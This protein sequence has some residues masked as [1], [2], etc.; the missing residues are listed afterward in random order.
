MRHKCPWLR[1]Q[2][3]ISGE[4]VLNFYF[5]FFFG[6]ITKTTVFVL[7]RWMFGCKTWNCLRGLVSVKPYSNVS[8]NLQQQAKI[9]I[10]S[11]YRFSPVRLNA[12]LDPSFSRFATKYPTA[13]IPAFY[14]RCS[15]LKL[16]LI[17]LDFFDI[18]ASREFFPNEVRSPE[19][20]ETSPMSPFKKI[21]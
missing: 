6:S 21:F 16:R 13:S 1:Q 14:K 12:H 7:S 5:L 2:C 19:I 15:I 8:D 3:W 17:F 11:I 18:R 4:I 20:G 10:K 9:L